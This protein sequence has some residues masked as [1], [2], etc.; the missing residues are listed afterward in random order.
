MTHGVSCEEFAENHTRDMTVRAGWGGFVP[1]AGV[2]TGFTRDALEKLAVASS[3]RIFDPEALTEDYSIG[4]RLFRLGCS[5]VFVPLSRGLVATREP[6]PE[7]WR[8]AL[9]QRTRWVTGIALQGWEQFGWTGSLGEVYWFWRDRKRLIGNP[10]SVAANVVFLYGWVARIWS[11][12]SPSMARLAAATL[13]LVALRSGVRMACCGRLYG[14]R[15]AWAAPLRAVYA[16]VLNSAATFN[17]VARYALARIRKKPLQ[18][19]KTDHAYP[20]R[21]ALMEHKRRLAEI[22]VASGYL[23]EDAS[24]EALET[25]PEE[26]RL[27]E[28]LV[29]SGFLTED[30]VYE[31]LSFQQGLPHVRI[32][33]ETVDPR[34][35]T[36]GACDTA[37]ERVAVS[38]RRGRFVPRRAG[39]PAHRS[40]RRPQEL[41]GFRSAISFGNSNR[42]SS[43]G[44]QVTLVVFHGVRTSC[45]RVG[46][47]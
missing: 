35:R 24:A 11:R 44:R 9:R 46:R 18:W 5:Q 38:S 6:F 21:T 36:S 41:H 29:A 32:E 25:I 42:V 12:V 37:V 16:N 14:F 15:F 31:G 7:C 3:N 1:S 4:L 47:A 39:A 34:A 28:H 43:A 26:V 17:A 27:G 30:E 20:S 10:L 40:Q 2:G 13:V 19:L 33:P 22:L 23:T 8:K 45:G